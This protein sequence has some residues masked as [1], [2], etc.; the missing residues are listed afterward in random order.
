MKSAFWCWGMSALAPQVSALR[1]LHST[2]SVC[3]LS[4]EQDGKRH[5]VGRVLFSLEGEFGQAGRVLWRDLETEED[6][7]VHTKQPH[8]HTHRTAHE[9]KAKSSWLLCLSVFR[10]GGCADI[11]QLQ[12][13]PAA[14]FSGGFEG[15]RHT[16]AHRRRYEVILWLWMELVWSTQI[17]CLSTKERKYEINLVMTKGM[18]GN[19]APVCVFPRC[20]CPG[21]LTKAHSGGEDEAQL[22]GERWKWPLLQL[23]DD[24]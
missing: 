3:V 22:C 20:V 24:L 12:Y 6:P 7:Q 8:T 15:S 16:A 17:H 5:V 2:L 19:T 23:Q 13:V 14:P 11:S 4:V 10:A 18:S 9:C 1:V 21:E